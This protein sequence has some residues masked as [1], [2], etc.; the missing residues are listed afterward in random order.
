MKIPSKETYTDYEST[1]PSQTQ[2]QQ[3]PVPFIKNTRALSPMEMPKKPKIKLQQSKSYNYEEE[4]SFTE[5]NIWGDK[6]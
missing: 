5:H 3:L 1:Q 2:I 4:E 6:E